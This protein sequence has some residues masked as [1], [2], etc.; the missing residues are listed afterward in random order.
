VSVSPEP[1]YG[2]ESAPPLSP[3]PP[4][5]P[6]P[7]VEFDVG[8]TEAVPLSP[9]VP[10]PVAAEFPELPESAAPVEVLPAPPVPPEVDVP[11]A[12]PASPEAEPAVAAPFGANAKLNAGP[13]TP[14]PESWVC[15]VSHAACASPIPECATERDGPEF[16][17]EGQNLQ[18]V[19]PP[20]A[21]ALCAPNAAVSPKIAAIRTAPNRSDIGI[22]SNSPPHRR[23][24]RR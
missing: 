13:V 15:P 5:P 24:K 14:A 7:A 3:E 10:P 4:P 18:S 1:T 19:E 20:A 21:M 9:E 11:V 22:P 8:A 2:S 17:D 12:E 23:P 16:P 6:V